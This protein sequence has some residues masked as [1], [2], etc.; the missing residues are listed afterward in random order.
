MNA[1]EMAMA[2][3]L[4]F[5][6]PTGHYYEAIT[7]HSGLQVIHADG[8]VTLRLGE[9]GARSCEL[10]ADG[11][12]TT[13]IRL[14]DERYPFE[15]TRYVRTWD[16][17]DA[18]ETWAE[19]RHGE[20][21]AVRL[22]RADSF[23][24]PVAVTSDVVRVLSLT[25]Q[26]KY[27]NN[28]VVSPVGKGQIVELASNSGGRN[29]WESNAAMMVEFG[30]VVDEERGTVLGLALEW[31]GTSCRRVR[32]NWNGKVVEVFAGV[33]MTTGPYTLD[34]GVTFTTPKAVLVWSERGRGE[35]SRQFHRWAHRHLMP[36]GYDLHPVLLNSWEG[37]YFSFTEQTLLDMMD[38]V[39]EMGGEMFV[40][41]DGW[42]GR[43]K[44]ARDEV[45]KA[46]AGLGDW[47]VNTNKLPHGL[48]WLAD[49]AAKRGLQFGLWV[50]PEMANTKSWLY[51]AHPDWVLREEGRP[52]VCGRGKTQVVLDFTNPAV[53]DGVFAQIDEVYSGIPSL[54]YVKWDCNANIWNP[55]SPYL[56]ADRQPN[57]WYDYAKGYTDLLARFQAK[58]PH[59][60][61]QA[62]ASGGGHMDFGSL[63]YADEF[64]ASDDTDPY[65]RIFIQWG[66]SQFYPASAMACHVT[67]SPNHQT[68]RET[69]LKYRFDVAM[70]GRLGFEL[71]PK[72][73]TSEELAFSKAAVA[74][75]KRIRP[76][77][78]CG[79]LYRLVSPYEEPLSA[80]MYVRDGERGTRNGELGR[81]DAVVFALGL[82]VEGERIETLKL[83][84]LDAGATYS[85]R[86]IN[87]G[88]RLHLAARVGDNAPCH[89]ATGRELM[90]RGLAVRLSGDYD[91]A[92]FE[93]V[94]DAASSRLDV[95]L[96][97]A[98]VGFALEMGGAA[99]GA[100]VR[101][102]GARMK[103]LE[104]VTNGGEVVA[105]WRGHPVCGDGFAVT[106]RMKPL[107]GGGFEY[108][109]FSYSGNESPLSVRRISFPE[110]TVPRTDKTAIFRP[111]T[112]G[113]VYR[114]KWRKFGAGR[115]V[116]TSGAN[117]LTFSCI[118]ALN[119]GGTSH[120]LDQRGEA[121]LHTTSFVVS[122]GE[123]PG[124]LV[125]KNVYVPPMAKGLR[126]AGGLPYG[127]VYAPY[128]G[129]WYEAAK[130]HREWFET[131]PWFKKAAARDFSRL[132][133]IALWMWSRGG[134]EVS[135]PPVHWFMKETGLKVGLDWYWWH[136]I[137]YD[138]SFPY[139]WPPRDG[140]E[141]FRAA[142]ARMK[143]AGAFVQTYTNGASWDCDD[144]RWETDG[145]IDCA[146][147]NPEGGLFA[148]MYN[149]F[150]RHRL[151]RMCG[152]A[153]KFQGIVRALERNLRESGLDGVY[154]DQISCGAHSPCYNPRHSHAPGGD[155]AER[156][157]RAYVQAVRDDNPGLVLSS[158]ATSETYF[159]AFE[160]SIL[161][162]SSWERCGKGLLPEHEPVPAATV[163]YRGANVI[164]GSFATP[165]GAPAW[166]P[167]WGERPDADEDVEAAVSKYADQFAV[168][169]A[170]GIVWGIQ[171]MVHNFT[172]KDVSNPR[173]AADLKFMKDSARFYFDN[174]DF[175]F[176]GEM[177]KPA[178][179]NCAKKR[180]KFLSA[181]CYTRVKDSATYVQKALPCVF[182]S[183]WRAKDGRRAAILVNWTREP[184]GYVLE[185]EGGRRE[186]T[187]APLSWARL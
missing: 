176:D 172:M 74:D 62:C 185:A 106:A 27:E 180:V 99:K 155:A 145:G 83:R 58:R 13:V 140:V 91:S 133:E 144:P 136:G 76:V 10:G 173:L 55:G 6:Q 2:G 134:V 184:Q 183:E 28:V 107:D 34:P 41:D 121:R 19:I 129:G 158:E 110:V 68:K 154:M 142:V 87:C 57:V 48:G 18:V 138:T 125:M 61:T 127:G 119:G 102:D 79:D 15:V 90:E 115:D 120:F 67:A 42:F 95:P 135:E 75:Y 45:N 152:E 65:Q 179:L 177:L 30:D 38:G 117:W 71:H 47:C 85:V 93:V 150:T 164:F 168:E 139:F 181:S 108:A 60:M 98:R 165:G 111:N 171:P 32:R 81:A 11:S 175:L 59:I 146:V 33:E 37:S 63:R 170:R 160:A 70:T 94:K 72:D 23:A 7:K 43:G 80:L 141:G 26:A 5:G 174:R 103:S 186:G 29:A 69:P 35:V 147:M 25:G 101:V 21:G 52:L 44:Y 22:V 39:K 156:G 143:K 53:R 14:K 31:P 114:P 77:V 187:L 3:Y 178:A 162:Y 153:P 157:F 109:A 128:S 86:E 182:H 66:A 64:W 105:T 104:V 12:K 84:G 96:G 166:D 73:M 40:L 161:L 112:V 159:D 92:V 50:E 20:R 123:E 78:Q 36:H 17:C 49:E 9:L 24:A 89:A 116:S 82:K 54:A 118:A 56:A 163:V 148:K 149:V 169:F 51:K 4:A 46:T 131:T 113:E 126:A 16:D 1:L 167:M 100:P 137:P 97:D 124:T 130:M 132:R 8:A 151:A 122:Q 88:E